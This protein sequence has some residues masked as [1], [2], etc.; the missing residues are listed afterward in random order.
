M[1]DNDTEVDILAINEE[2][3]TILIGE[4]K[5]KDVVLH[6]ILKITPKI[7]KN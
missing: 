7:M 2:E 6:R 3:K 5:Y 4:C 1:G